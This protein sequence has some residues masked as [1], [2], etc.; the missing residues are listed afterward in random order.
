MK[1]SKLKNQ[2]IPF[3]V[4]TSVDDDLERVVQFGQHD[5]KNRLLGLGMRIRIWSHAADVWEGQFKKNELHGFGRWTSVFQDGQY[6]CQV[7]YWRNGWRHGWNQE[8]NAKKTVDGY[9]EKDW[10]QSKM[11]QEIKSYDAYNDRICQEID[12]NDYLI[13]PEWKGWK[14]YKK[15]KA[16]EKGE[17]KRAKIEKTTEFNFSKGKK[18]HEL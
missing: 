17:D 7:G 4:H 1:R 10:R 5:S 9:Y 14:E 3:S 13:K 11:K 6:D 12:I 2:V 8:I 18:Y 15:R 16:A